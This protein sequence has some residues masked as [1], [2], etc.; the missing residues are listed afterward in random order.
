M[1]VRVHVRRTEAVAVAE[2]VG[3]VA[4]TLTVRMHDRVGGD[5]EKVSVS[6]GCDVGEG[7]AVALKE[8]V[9]GERVRREVGVGGVGVRVG[10]G[11]T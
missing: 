5:R 1:Q 11:V 10:E 7:E 4:D 9:G 2:S 8:G 6:E 3:G